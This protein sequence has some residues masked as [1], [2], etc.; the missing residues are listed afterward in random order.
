MP[1]RPTLVLNKNYEGRNLLVM[2]IFSKTNL[3]PSYVLEANSG[4]RS[5]AVAARSRIE[6]GPR[7]LGQC[8]N[9]WLPGT[10]WPKKMMQAMN[11]TWGSWS[12]WII[13]SHFAHPESSSD[14]HPFTKCCV[15]ILWTKSLFL[16]CQCTRVSSGIWY[17][18]VVWWRYFLFITIVRNFACAMH[19]ILWSK[20]TG[21]VVF[22]CWPFSGVGTGPIRSPKETTNNAHRQAMLG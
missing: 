8:G 20:M 5:I 10:L 6:C 15:V 12:I 19:E 13:L 7:E 18:L 21:C 4:S 14:H 2:L 16:F 22:F 9:L 11:E 1:T 17:V 3:A